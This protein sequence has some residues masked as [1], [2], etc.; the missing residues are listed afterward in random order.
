MT[1]S[2]DSACRGVAGTGTPNLKSKAL[3][4]SGITLEGKVQQPMK[5]TLT[6]QA[7]TFG[8]GITTTRQRASK[9]DELSQIHSVTNRRRYMISPTV[10]NINPALP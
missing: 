10:D 8:F 6:S 2:S 9:R 1:I 7:L 3:N 5:P 4:Y